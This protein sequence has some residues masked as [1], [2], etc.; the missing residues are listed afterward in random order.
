VIAESSNILMRI[1]LFI[2]TRFSLLNLHIKKLQLKYTYSRGRKR[3]RKKNFQSEYTDSGIV[4]LGQ[5]LTDRV[6]DNYHLKYKYKPLRILFQMPPGGVG[7]LWFQD[8]INCL[9]HTGIA[10]DAI[11]RNSVNF[12]DKLE[13]FKP[14]VFIS[15]DESEVLRSPDIAVLLKYKKDNGCLR[16]FTPISCHRFP[17]PGMSDEDKWR[18]EEAVSG[19]TADAFFSMMAPEFFQRFLPEWVL[20]GFKHLSLPNA[21]N[22]LVHKPVEGEKEFDYFIATSFGDERFFLTYEYLRP[23]FKKYYGLFAGPGW[24]FGAGAIP[25]SEM[26]FLYSRTKIVPNPLGANRFLVQYPAEIT[27]RAFSALSCGAFQITELT[28]VTRRF[29]DADELTCV[30]GKKEFIE[31]FDYYIN[32]PDERNS[33]VQKGMTRLYKEHTYFHR[34]DLLIDFIDSCRSLF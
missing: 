23:I 11:K 29:F 28:P 4:L 10:S 32:K 21:C 30:T 27:E 25:P 8:I 12:N 34:I 9:N 18:L 15:M 13:T 7:T 1:L 16:L 6:L 24:E 20:H 5:S 19:R 3:K 26:P 17:E 14:N 22:P 31:A 2:K 33:I